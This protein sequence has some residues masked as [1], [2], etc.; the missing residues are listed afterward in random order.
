MS[1][2]RKTVFYRYSHI[3]VSG[4]EKSDTL[5]FDIAAADASGKYKEEI[6]LRTNRIYPF[7]NLTLIVEQTVMP[8]RDTHCDT[9]NCH[10]ISADGQ[11]EGYGVG[12]Y[13]YLFNLK[14]INL[15][16]GDSLHIRIR[17]DMRREILPGITDVGVKITKC[18]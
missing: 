16:K 17:H 14:D 5:T 8:S 6:G 12:S 9:L 13:Q 18:R 10:L 7:V 1:C 4:W 11:S 3:P 2:N 15:D